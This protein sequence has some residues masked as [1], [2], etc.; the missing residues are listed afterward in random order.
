VLGHIDVDLVSRPETSLRRATVRSAG[1]DDAA[2]SELDSRDIRA[3]TTRSMSAP[4][5]NASFSRRIAGFAVLFLVPLVLRSLP[6]EHGLPRNYIPDTNVARAALGMA[7][8]KDLVP[9]AGKYSHYP[10]LVPYA[11]LPLYAAQ[12][13]VGKLEGKWD[14]TKAFG[15]HM[16]EHPEDAQLLARWLV[17]ILGALT[18]LVMFR[19][20]RAA[21]LGRGAWIAAWLVATGLLHLEFS[22][23]E[24]PW[25]PMT[26]FFVLALWPAILYTNG[27]RARHLLW[28]GVA[29]GGAFACHQGGLA[30]IGIPALAWL[31]GPLAWTGRDLMRRLGQGVACVALFAAIALAVGYPHF[32]RYGKT[33]PQAVIGG[34]AVEEQG[35]LQI[36]GMS[37]LF[38]VRWDSARRLAIAL[39]GYDPVV[40]VLG[41]IG[42]WPA[43]RRRTLRAPTLFTLA[44]GAF[45]LTNQND[46]VRY[47]LPVAVLLV[48]PAALVLERWFEHGRARPFVYTLLAIPLVQAARFDFLMRKSDT[49]AEAEKR[50]A[51]LRDHGLVAIDRYGPEVDLDRASLERLL[52]L[53]TSRHEKLRT[54]EEHRRHLFDRE[55]VPAD[56][57]GVN[58]VRIE[59]LFEIDERNGTIRLREGLEPLGRDAREALHSLGVRYVMIVERRMHGGA[60]SLLAPLVED[61]QPIVV[62]DPSCGSSRTSEAFLPTEMDFPLTALWTV[63]RPGPWMAIHELH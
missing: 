14:G 44:W 63:N 9:P 34:E 55:L 52:R 35:G 13:E 32:I 18:P 27:G 45:F 7:R 2:V 16:L 54:R 53:R 26:F 30:A 15:D 40:I 57:Q 61:A 48:L 39:V 56:E 12:Y 6:I 42:L 50:I 22:V 60:Q 4:R 33:P 17:A 20:A 43:L 23:H 3:G 41:W 46:H 36:G 24:R 37:I 11:L 5:A 28:S 62:I 1:A 38:G 59:E 25:A 29:A 31:F 21:G 8:D 49:R 10:N 19:A 58:A 51:E 47:L